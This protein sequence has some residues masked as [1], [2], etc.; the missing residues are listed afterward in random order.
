M[1]VGQYLGLFIDETREHLQELNKHIIELEKS[2]QSKEVIDEIFRIAHTLK[3]MAGTVGFNKVAGLTHKMENVL[4]EVRE[5][6]L[7]V[8]TNIVDILFDCLD[9]LQA[10]IDK[11]IETGEEGQDE[12]C[13]NAIDALDYVSSNKGN[14]EKKGLYKTNGKGE[15]FFLHEYDKN[16]IK[17]ALL[18]NLNIYKIKFQLSEDCVMKAARAFI[19]FKK[20][21]EISDVIKSQPSVEDIEDEKFEQEFTVLIISTETKEKVKEELES[22]SNVSAINIE[23]IKELDKEKDANDIQVATNN[24]NNLNPQ[25]LSSKKPVMDKKLNKSKVMQTV[26]VS[27][28]KLDSL[29]NLV[30]ELIII[31]T[32][33][34]VDESKKDASV[35]NGILENMERT[36]SDLH[37]AVMQARMVPIEMVFN[38][39]PRMVRDFSRELN[40]DIDLNIYGAETELDRTV[41]DE[42]SDPLIHL[43]RNSIDHGIEARQQ[44]LNS[45]KP[46]KGTI[47]LKAYHDKDMVV[48]EV[49]DDGAGINIEEIKEKA[50]E[51]GLIMHKIAESL[52]E[53]E[54]IKFLFQPNFSTTNKVTDI[55]GRGVG[56][57]V[58]KTKIQSLGGSIEVKTKLNQG[59]RFKIKLPL[60]LAIIQVLLIRLEEE[61]YAIPISSII[62][63]LNLG[64]NEISILQGQKVINFRNN[65]IPVLALKYVLKIKETSKDKSLKNKRLIVVKKADK[66]MALEIDE[67]IG[68]QEIVIK[69]LSKHLARVKNIAGATI[70]GNG[71]V[72]LI[73]DVKSLI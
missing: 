11:I 60:T 55:S 71:Q 5:G 73:L 70:L 40:K 32:Q 18:K 16:I 66:Y 29:M 24:I 57:D 53:E 12:L 54:A 37:D 4:Q 36:I 1:D 27:I 34:Q 2:P 33:L 43:I 30:S 17:H 28:D 13:N 21:E 63:I 50:I 47:I 14:S 72:V 69:P 26:R 68:Q 38:R 44:R 22:I 65:V 49:Q 31:K 8:T 48:V 7:E 15:E 58:V 64:S 45:N 3:G 67:I 20:L 10:Y 42:I 61:K 25:Q 62:E 6:K 41:I 56:L 9:V 51:K 23:Q 19:I 52:S 59:S 35:N 39:F 46:G